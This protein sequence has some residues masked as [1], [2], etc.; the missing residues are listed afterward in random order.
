MAWKTL[1]QMDISGKRVLVRVD[2]NVPVED[3]RVTDAPASSELPPPCAT[4][5]MRVANRSCSHISGGPKA[6]ACR[7]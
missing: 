4:F 1:D 3:G 5:W 2:I 7:R 6:S